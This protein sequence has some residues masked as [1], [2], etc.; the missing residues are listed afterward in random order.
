MA[1]EPVDDIVLTVNV[2]YQGLL[3]E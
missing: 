3:H 1:P 2:M